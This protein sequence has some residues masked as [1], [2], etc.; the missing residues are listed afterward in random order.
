MGRCGCRG[1]A[2]GRRSDRLSGLCRRRG[3][4]GPARCGGRGCPPDGR[5]T[6]TAAGRAPACRRALSCCGPACLTRLPGRRGSGDGLLRLARWGRADGGLRCLTG[7]RRGDVR[8][9]RL[10]RWPRVD[11]RLLRRALRR[12][13]TGCLLGLPRRWL[14]CSFLRLP[15]RCLACSFLRL[16]RRQLPA[17]ILGVLGRRADRNAQDQS[18]YRH[19]T[20][21]A[22]QRSRRAPPRL[23]RPCCHGLPS[24]G[25]LPRPRC[26]HRRLD[27]GANKHV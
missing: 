23:V 8:L 14:A 25:R 2:T 9:L 26:G 27:P 1:P 11:A 19:R 10:A 5:C 15:G 4:H 16:P 12:R 17:A 3:S 7:W 6:R 18:G 13:A 20:C 21:D 24:L 22:V